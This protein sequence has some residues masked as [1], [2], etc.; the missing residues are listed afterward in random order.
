MTD[1][2]RPAG[3]ALLALVGLDQTIKS[4]VFG[5]NPDQT[6]SSLFCEAALLG[7]RW[8]RVLVWI[9][10]RLFWFAEG[11]RLGH[12]ERAFR[13]DSERHWLPDGTLPPGDRRSQKKWQC[14]RRRM[15][16]GLMKPKP[17]FVKG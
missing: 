5:G 12:C 17:Y 8:G 10:D 16:A 15:R 13:G 6:L 7:L 9:T 2:N 14:W 11:R 4:L 3:R 1:R